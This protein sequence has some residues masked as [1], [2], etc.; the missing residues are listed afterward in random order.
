[1]EQIRKVRNE[2]FSGSNTKY[3]ESHQPRRRKNIKEGDKVKKYHRETSI[4]KKLNRV[5]T[6]SETL[7]DNMEAN[8]KNPQARKRSQDRK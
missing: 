7:R 6:V 1:M 8:P 5:T 2:K 4:K 3:S